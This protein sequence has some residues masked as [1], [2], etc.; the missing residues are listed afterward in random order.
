MQILTSKRLMA[1]IISFTLIFVF[2]VFQLKAQQKTSI[3]G[4]ITATYT[5]QEAIEVGDTESHIIS[6][7]KSEGTNVSTGEHVFMDSAQVVNISLGDLVKGTGINQGYV[8]FT[9]NS[10]T[11]FANWQ[12]KVTTILSTEGTPIT[13]LEGTFSFI[14]GKGQFKN[15]QGTGTFKVKFIAEKTYISEWEGEYFIKK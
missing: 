7:A 14:N 8:K 2:N 5:K 10:D 13:T 15:M 4:K 11:T 3:A 6:I 1:L 12:S 9:K